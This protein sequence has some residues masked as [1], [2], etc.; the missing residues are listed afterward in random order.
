MKVTL[1]ERE[2]DQENP[3]RH[4]ATVRVKKELQPTRETI[5]TKEDV[6]QKGLTGVLQQLESQR[7]LTESKTEELMKWRG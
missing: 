1:E 2:E 6:L 3:T 7:Q 4:E 5:E